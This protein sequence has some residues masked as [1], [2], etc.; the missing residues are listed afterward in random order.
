[1][2]VAVGLAVRVFVT[3]ELAV[4]VFVIVG[5]RVDVFVAIGLAV[6]VFVTVGMAVGISVIVGLEVGVF[7]IVGVEVNTCVGVLVG[8]APLPPTVITNWGAFAPPSR[9][10][11]LTAVLLFPVIARL[12]VPLSAIRG[13]ISTLVQDPLLKEPM[14]PAR[15]PN[16]GA[17][18]YVIVVSPQLVS[19]TL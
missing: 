15:L 12:I 6:A 11:K 4:G 10:T 2:G 7:V 3:V 17:L 16:G 19:G 9:L 8:L 5:L 13:V 18:L 1:M 14:D